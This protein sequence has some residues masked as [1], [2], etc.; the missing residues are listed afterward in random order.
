MTDGAQSVNGWLRQLQGLLGCFVEFVDEDSAE[1][2]AG[3]A[4]EDAF[5]GVVV[6][7]ACEDEQGFAGEVGGGEHGGM[8]WY[9]PSEGWR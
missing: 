5:G 8:A 3:G 6:A 2:S 9:E 4:V 1:A 7:R